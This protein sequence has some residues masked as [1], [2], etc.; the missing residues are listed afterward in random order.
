MQPTPA[1]TALDPDPLA[2]VSPVDARV[3]ASGTIE[4]GGVSK[5][6]GVA[7]RAVGSPLGDAITAAA[8]G[9]PMHVAGHLRRDTWGGREKLEL[10]IE[11][12][13]DPRRQ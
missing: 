3:Y 2:I 11:D 13:A 5:L 10:Q 1:P 9:L 4:A 6:E 12:V 7:F 8:G